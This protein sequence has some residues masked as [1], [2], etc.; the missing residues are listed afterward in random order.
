MPIVIMDLDG[1]I[2]DNSHRAHLAPPHDQRH[3][4]KAWHPFVAA[5]VDDAVIHAGVMLYKALSAFFPVVIITSRQ[6][7]F[8]TITANWFRPNV[9]H[10]GAGKILYRPNGMSST[11]AEYKRWRL[12]NLI[13]DG[14]TIAMAIDDDPAVIA[15]YQEEG[16]PTYQAS[17]ICSS[18]TGISK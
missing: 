14:Y 12:H 13:R 2:C 15:M 16:V 7:K 17:T 5:C 4:N 6:V 18:L 8:E 1:V 3:I 11:P 10:D 9:D